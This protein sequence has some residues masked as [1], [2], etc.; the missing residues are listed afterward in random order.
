MKY[1][2]PLIRLWKR[3]QVGNVL[4]IVSSWN[5]VN[6]KQRARSDGIKNLMEKFHLPIDLRRQLRKWAV[7][8][9]LAEGSSLSFPRALSHGLVS[10]KLK[11]HPV[12]SYLLPACEALG[13]RTSRYR[14]CSGTRD[15]RHNLSGAGAVA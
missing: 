3:W 10:V 1:P 15:H 9:C 14:R 8:G 11:G 6:E 12:V 7:S 2:P 4:G 5:T 13:C